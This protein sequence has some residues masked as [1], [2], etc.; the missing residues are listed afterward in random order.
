MSINLIGICSPRHCRWTVFN[1]TV[2]ITWED[3]GTYEMKVDA[4]AGTMDG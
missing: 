3:L 1:D 4:C 2:T